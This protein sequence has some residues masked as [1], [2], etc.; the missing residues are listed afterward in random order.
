[1]NP[2]WVR[3]LDHL[4]R[5]L[6]GLWAGLL[7]CVAFVATPAPFATLATADAGR[8]VARIFSVEAP[9]SLLAGGLL[10]VWARR[11]AAAQVEAGSAGASQFSLDMMLALGAV[12]CTVAGYYGLQP[13]MAAARAG[14]SALS[15]GQW[16]AVSLGLFALKG[17]MVLVLAWRAAR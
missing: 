13:A 1:M 15:F 9:L 3:R 6:P 16:H 12:F 14:N 17:L 7:L 11:R 5:L 8:V 4:A 2:T 10:L